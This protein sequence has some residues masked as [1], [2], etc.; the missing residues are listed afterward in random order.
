MRFT[1]G[2]E[3]KTERKLHYSRHVEKANFLQ[4]YKI[5]KLLSLSLTTYPPQKA[6]FGQASWMDAGKARDSAMMR[7]GDYWAVRGVSDS[8]ARKSSHGGPARTFSTFE[9]SSVS[10]EVSDRADPIDGCL[11][12][13]FAGSPH[14]I[15]SEARQERSRRVLEV[16]PRIRDC[17]VSSSI[18]VRERLVDLLTSTKRLEGGGG[19]GRRLRRR[20]CCYCLLSVHLQQR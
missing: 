13:R 11:L 1:G 8:R 18:R 17:F 9:L 15:A 2:Q 3:D 6:D 14:R 7:E 19:G 20:D 16:Y 10:T 5:A 4:I 12:T